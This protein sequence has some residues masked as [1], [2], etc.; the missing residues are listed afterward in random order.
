MN[1]LFS[2]LLPLSI[3]FSIQLVWWRINLPKHQGKVLLMIFLATG[4]VFYGFQYFVLAEDLLKI[5][6]TSFSYCVITLGYLIS[7][8][9]IEA[10]SPTSLILLNL[11]KAEP[12]GL[13]LKDLEGII[14]DELFFNDRLSSL[15]RSHYVSC[16]Q[17]K[18]T[19]TEQG[20]KYLRFF[21]FPKRM[22]G[23][24]EGG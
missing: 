13:E 6:A 5:S 24:S 12:K 14:T 19:I 2:T 9:A 4:V 20:R 8:T 11:K 16:N 15:S 23:I 17:E 18:M 22:L 21:T 7:Y 3:A 1:L 10:E